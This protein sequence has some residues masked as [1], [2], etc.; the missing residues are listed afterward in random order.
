MKE[1]GD[2]A[3]SRR[4]AGSFF[5]TQITLILADDADSNRKMMG[6]Q[7]ILIL[8]DDADSNRKMMGYRSEQS[9]LFHAAS[10]IFPRMTIDSF[11]RTVRM[12]NSLFDCKSS[13]ILVYFQSEI[14]SP[15]P[16]KRET[17]GQKSEITLGS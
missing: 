13:S 11:H 12:S 6:T 15:L 7:I 16:R 8:A 10:P 4:A 9:E 2:K 14:G 3:P 1:K 5:W 17:R